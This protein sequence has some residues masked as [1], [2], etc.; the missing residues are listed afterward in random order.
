MAAGLEADLITMLE[1]G[2]NSGLE[3]ALD[4]SCLRAP[5]SEHPF[6]AT[7]AEERHV[8]FRTDPSDVDG[9]GG[10]THPQLAI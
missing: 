5:P 10:V 6:Y 7:N 2:M 9:I 3:A 1:D 8:S 4:C